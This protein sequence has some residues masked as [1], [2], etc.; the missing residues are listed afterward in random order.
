M[1]RKKKCI[2]HLSIAILMFI[3]WTIISVVWSRE[4][5]N[6]NMS[7]LNVDLCTATPIDSVECLTAFRH[8]TQVT[9]NLTF[10]DISCQYQAACGQIIE[11][12]VTCLIHHETCPILLSVYHDQVISNL[13]TMIVVLPTLGLITCAMIY[14]GV[15]VYIITRD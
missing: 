9:Y 7:D 10:D 2:V 8:A 15:V 13:I 4:V 11:K 1:N 14:A 3:V 5:Y 6:N 12:N